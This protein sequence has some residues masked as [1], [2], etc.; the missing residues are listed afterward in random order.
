MKLT[1]ILQ[2]VMTEIGNSSP[3]YS[4]KV[5]DDEDH[6]IYQ[7]E[8]DSK[9]PTYYEVELNELE[10]HQYKV[11]KIGSGVTLAINF[12]VTDDQGH[13]S[14][15]S[16][17]NKGELY[18]VMA[19]VVDIVNKDIKEHPYINTLEFTSSKRLDKDTQESNAREKLYLKYIEMNYKE[20]DISKDNSSDTITVKLK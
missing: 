16:L 11:Y 1:K 3:Y 7:F 10:P 2:E 8:T 13:K 5:I 14:T 18:K 4:E 17:T 6:R 19:T 15:K 20:A 9:P 12:G